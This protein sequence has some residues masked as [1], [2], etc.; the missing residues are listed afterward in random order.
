VR[1]RPAEYFI[2]HKPKGVVCT[3]K[4]PAGRLRAVDLL[5]PTGAPLFPVGRLDADSTGLLLLTND[6]DLAQRITHPR[7][8]IEKVYRAEVRKA[9][10][11][12]IVD[13][14][15]A[16]MFFAEGKVR[17]SN[18]E[19]THRG[20]DHGVLMI[21]LR[22]GRN[23]QVRRML[24][25]LGYPVRTLKRLFIGQLSLKGLPVGSARRL[26]P[27]EVAALREATGGVG[28]RVPRGRMG[29]PVRVAAGRL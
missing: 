2:L 1:P 24:A 4:D 13:Q 21:T 25:K 20:R 11:P 23:R 3:H 17:A 5:P 27:R 8:G 6:G 29:S 28:P 16:G 22:E 18:V 12:E 9:V 10:S 15:K 7:Y 26:T 19:I 14:M